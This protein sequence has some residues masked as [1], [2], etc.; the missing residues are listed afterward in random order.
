MKNPLTPEQQKEH[1][2]AVCSYLIDFWQS[3]QQYH[4]RQI[5]ITQEKIARLTVE[6]NEH[7]AKLKAIKEAS[8]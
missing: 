1:S 2:I 7:R 6:R 3:Q 8:E 5:Y 4:K